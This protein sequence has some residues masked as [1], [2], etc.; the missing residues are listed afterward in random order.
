MISI[1][2][3]IRQPNDPLEKIPIKNLADK[4]RNPNQKFIDYIVQLRKIIA[5]DVKK[6]RELK[7]RLPYVVA[8]TFNPPFRK[9]ENFAS[10]KYFILDIDHLSD[11]EIDIENLVKR[12]TS[13]DR[14]AL[15]FKSPSNDGL[16]LFFKTEYTFT[17]PGKYSLFY[18]TFAH[19]FA[20]EYSLQQVVDK[21]T[22]DVSRA[23][24]VSYDPDVWYNENAEVIKIDKYI[25]F[26]NQL[27]VMEIESL[28]KEQEKQENKTAVN[29]ETDITKQDI[30]T[31][32]IRQIREKLNPRIKIRREKKIYVPEELDE[33]IDTVKNKL[34]EFGFEV[35]EIININYG[36]QFRMKINH[37]KAEINVFYGRK[38]YSVV[39]STKS[40][41]NT[42]LVD[43]A[44]DIIASVLL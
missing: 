36:K 40:G 3:N 44:H 4:I 35:E 13:D 14:I 9:I 25:D 15:L 23:C 12:F 10:T 27:Q 7:T 20:L 29:T 18:K 11:K 16:K 1:G 34:K 21:R 43:V 39:K 41:M 26:D 33:I 24:F 42:Q 19:G 38:G 22:S 2:K 5:I 17:D 6:Y 30:D 8:A 37:L 31:D 32:I 28:L